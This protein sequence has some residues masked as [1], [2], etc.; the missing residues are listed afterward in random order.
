MQPRR[1]VKSRA[2]DPTYVY[3]TGS[4][5]MSPARET[6]DISIAACSRAL[7]YKLGSSLGHKISKNPD[8]VAR[9]MRDN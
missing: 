1:D 6:K 8:G 9:F 4:D 2:R 3:P 7:S 5:P